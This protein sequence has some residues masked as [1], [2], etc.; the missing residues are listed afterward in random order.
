MVVHVLYQ[1][2]LY[3]KFQLVKSIYLPYL[4]DIFSLEMTKAHNNGA[5]KC[6]IAQY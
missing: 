3:D 6:G 5:Y 2:N 1:L 4:L